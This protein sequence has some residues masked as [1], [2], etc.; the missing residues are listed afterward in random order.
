[1]GMG[2]NG[3]KIPKK[4]EDKYLVYLIASLLLNNACYRKIFHFVRGCAALRFP[5]FCSNNVYCAPFVNILP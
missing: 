2:I 1:M 4:E 3:K 5:C